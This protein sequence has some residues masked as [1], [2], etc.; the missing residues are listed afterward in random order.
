[1]GIFYFELNLRDIYVDL[2]SVYNVISI[3]SGHLWN[4]TYDYFGVW[5]QVTGTSQKWVEYGRFQV[6]TQNS[7]FYWRKHSVIFCGSWN[8]LIP[9]LQVWNLMQVLAC[10]AHRGLHEKYWS[11][12]LNLTLHLYSNQLLQTVYCQCLP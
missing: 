1:M 4:K 12:D 5:R 9:S 7:R 8:H 3:N 11:L 10:N 6:W 2:S